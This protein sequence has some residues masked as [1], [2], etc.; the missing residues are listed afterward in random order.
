MEPGAG[1]GVGSRSGSWGRSRGISRGI[2]IDG[3]GADPW[4]DPGDLGAFHGQ[5]TQR[6]LFGCIQGGSRVDPGVNPMA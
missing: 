4:I 3:S 1:L 2:F 6:W 5:W